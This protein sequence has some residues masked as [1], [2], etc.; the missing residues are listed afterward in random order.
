MLRKNTHFVNILGKY[1]YF[2]KKSSHNF[3]HC[4]V[5]VPNKIS[6]FLLFTKT[7]NF[8]I[9]K[10]FLYRYM[11]KLCTIQVYISWLCNDVNIT[12][13]KYSVVFGTKISHFYPL[14]ILFSFS[15]CLVQLFKIVKFGNIWLKCEVIVSTGCPPKNLM[16][17]K[18]TYSRELSIVMFSMDTLYIYF[19][20]VLAFRNLCSSFECGWETYSFATVFHSVYICNYQQALI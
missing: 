17:L 13:C 9:F 20:R 8:Y 15:I 7:H 10:H 18:H 16:Q 6:Q 19:I 2:P 3:F 1:S 4:V 11:I 5:Q 12:A 14:H